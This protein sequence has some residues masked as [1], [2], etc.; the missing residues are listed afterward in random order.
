MLKLLT[1]LLLSSLTA[2]LLSACSEPPQKLA[3]FRHDNQSSFSADVADDGTF[4]LVAN[5]DGSASLW[6]AD[7]RG[8]Y[9]HWRHN[10]GQQIVDV[11]I[12]AS[13][14]VA[15]LAD[16]QDFSLWQVSSGESLGYW[17]IGNGRIHRLAVSA[18]GTVIVLAKTNGM[19][20]AFNP[21]SGRRLEFY[22]HSE[23]VNALAIS[24]NG[25]Y[26]LSGSNDHNA[27]LWDTESGQIVHRWQH[28]SRVTQVALDA[29]GRYAFSA[30]S[31][32]NAN[33]WRLPDGQRQTKLRF[34]DR[35]RIFSAATFSHDGRYFIT[36]APSRRITVWQ[37]SDGEALRHWSINLPE[38][39]RPAS[40]AV[41]ALGLTRD[42][43]QLLSE[44]SAGLAERWQ[45]MLGQDSANKPASQ[46]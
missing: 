22:G 26:V 20:I 29:Q 17:H 32:D 16:S 2:T 19:Q 14:E 23:R 31:K 3:E 36:G 39:H 35:Q 38:Q 43:N 15:A 24:A 10:S 11:D 25:R 4:S 6:F 30:D 9:Y 13:G 34:F 12:S 18:N 7:E 33:I 41:L 42:D 1:A 8:D 40:A 27:I 44:S 46:P 5:D 21:N 45:I 28:D 37:V